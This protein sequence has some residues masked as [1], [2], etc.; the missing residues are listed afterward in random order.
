MNTGAVAAESV[1]LAGK[2]QI[3]RRLGQGDMPLYTLTIRLSSINNKI[4]AYL[5]F[6]L[7]IPD[8]HWKF[9]K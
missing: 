5:L 9:Y 8:T 4:F 6:Y 7:V 3:T 2:T 1:A